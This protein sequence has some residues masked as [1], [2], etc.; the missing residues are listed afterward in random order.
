MVI[1]LIVLELTVMVN[2]VPSHILII[3]AAMKLLV[4]Y[5]RHLW[6]YIRLIISGSCCILLLPAPFPES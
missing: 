6:Y 3:V 2:I 4:S 1:I 5:I